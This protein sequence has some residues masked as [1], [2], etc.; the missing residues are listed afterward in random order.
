MVP[1]SPT[2][3]EFER[4]KT[5]TVKWVLVFLNM[6]PCDQTADAACRIDSMLS[7]LSVDSRKITNLAFVASD[8]RVDMQAVM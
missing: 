7:D 4:H 6:R 5:V 1:G 2:P 3:V 8:V